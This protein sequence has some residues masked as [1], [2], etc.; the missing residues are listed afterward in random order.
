MSAIGGCDIESVKPTGKDLMTWLHMSKRPKGSNQLNF[1]YL[2]RTSHKSEIASQYSNDEDEEMSENNDAW[3]THLVSFLKHI[4]KFNWNNS[5]EHLPQDGI[6]K[7]GLFL[8]WLVDDT[9][10]QTFYPPQK[11]SPRNAW[12]YVQT[13]SGVMFP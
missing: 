12:E 13:N 5:F 2:F 11:R 9:F 4:R 8:L 1:F 7:D 10:E 3:I 6:D